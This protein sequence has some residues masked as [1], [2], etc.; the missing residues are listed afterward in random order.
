MFRFWCIFP[1]LLSDT[2]SVTMTSELRSHIDIPSNEVQSNVRLEF[3]LREQETKRNQRVI[4]HPCDNCTF[5]FL[6]MMCENTD[7]KTK[8]LNL[9]FRFWQVFSYKDISQKRNMH[10]LFHFVS[11][12]RSRLQAR[13]Y[14]DHPWLSRDE[15]VTVRP[16]KRPTGPVVHNQAPRTGTTDGNHKYTLCS[17]GHRWRTLPRKGY[18]HSLLP[19]QETRNGKR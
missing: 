14:K 10:N 7:T 12:R 8:T 19:R 3:L 13:D 6:G 2:F 15:W 16:D 4:Q 11:E 18:R 9:T 5:F 17:L 1:L